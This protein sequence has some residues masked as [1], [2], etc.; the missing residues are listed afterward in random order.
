[1]YRCGYWVLL[2]GGIYIYVDFLVIIIITFPYSTC[3]SSFLAAAS[4]TSLFILK[5]FSF[6]ILYSRWTYPQHQSPYPRP[7][8]W[9]QH[10]GPHPPPPLQQALGNTEEETMEMRENL[11][12]SEHNSV[13][14]C[15]LSIVYTCICTHIVTAHRIHVYLDS[16]MKYIG[17]WFS[18]ILI[19]SGM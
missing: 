17:S 7:H 16:Y 8:Q 3:I 6:F 18:D 10:R 12:R 11:S 4:R 19:F 5:C 2:S 9:S 13:L 14:Y 1:M 15:I